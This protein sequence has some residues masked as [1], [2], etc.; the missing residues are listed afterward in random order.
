MTAAPARIGV[1]AGAVL[2]NRRG[3]VLLVKPTYKAG[4]NLPGGR[5][6]EGESPREAC[7]RD[8]PG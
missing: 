6:D 5:W 3:E 8:F 7:V 1:S 2:T 4:W